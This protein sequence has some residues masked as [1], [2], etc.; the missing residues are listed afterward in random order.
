MKRQQN[1]KDFR[2]FD[3]GYEVVA[4]MVRYVRHE[5]CSTQH[6]RMKLA[7]EN[8]ES[9]RKIYER[10]LFF[11]SDFTDQKFINDYRPVLRANERYLKSKAAGLSISLHSLPNEI[12]INDRQ[13]FPELQL[14]IDECFVCGS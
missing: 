8:C 2:S 6:D 4:R 11:Q 5:L 14:D 3:Q 10:V 12:H 7:I 1:P 9:C 13:D